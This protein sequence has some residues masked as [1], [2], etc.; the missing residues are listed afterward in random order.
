ME[1]FNYNEEGEYIPSVEPVMAK[2]SPLEPGEYLI[3]RNATTIEPE[4]PLTDYANFFID[5]EWVPIL[6]NRGSYYNADGEV[7]EVTDINADVTDLFLFDPKSLDKAKA[8][9]TSEINAA[10]NDAV[11][12]FETSSEITMDA[13]LAKIQLLKSGFD[14]AEA[15]GAPGMS[16]RDFYNVTH[17]V[18][19]DTLSQMLNELGMNYQANLEQ[20]WNAQ[21]AV[22]LATTEEELEGIG[23]T[24]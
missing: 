10:F 9:K 22:A 12:S 7:V 14:L 20:K 19:L 21:D 18:S 2:E 15:L 24:V 13:A 5:G 3:P 4:Y 11:S 16:I 6:D 8:L 17:A 23:F 1:I